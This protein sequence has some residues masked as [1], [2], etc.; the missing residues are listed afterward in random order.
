MLYR[1]K[2]NSRQCPESRHVKQ[3]KC[4]VICE[5][6]HS[7]SIIS[8]KSLTGNDE[9][10]SRWKLAEPNE[11]GTQDEKNAKCVIKD[12]QNNE[13]KQIIEEFYILYSKVL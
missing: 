9:D 10:K 4:I 13:M 1:L 3:T 7:A 8:S 2:R 6:M 11:M 12:K 5:E